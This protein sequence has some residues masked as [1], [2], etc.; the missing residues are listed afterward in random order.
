VKKSIILFTLFISLSFFGQSHQQNDTFEIVSVLASD[1]LKGRPTSSIYEEKS[2]AYI[3]K[4]LKQIKGSKPKK[5][6]FTFKRSQNV[7]NQ[8]S[9]NIYWHINNKADSTIVISAHYDHLGT[10]EGLSRSFGKTGIHFGADDNASG[11]ALTI[12]L[13]NKY[14]SYNT[15]K[16]NYLFVFYSAHEIGLF[17]SQA[18]AD[19]CSKK[20]KPLALV[21]NFDM[22]GRLEP[23]SKILNVYGLTTLKNH[24]KFFNAVSFPGKTYTGESY[25]IEESDCKWFIKR[26]K[27][28]SF[29][30]GIHEDYHKISDTADKIN[31]EG[32]LLIEKYIINLL[33]S[34]AKS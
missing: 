21:I 17:G 34:F 10:G 15:K 19:F 24:N 12:A 20:F 1:S 18:F 6:F 27:C 5:H 28:L 3:I 25:K 8:K 4:K 9:T 31:F 14:S 32:I 30:T 23:E 22:V 26:S 7:E 2:V 33:N 11:V 13:A 16:F 29:S